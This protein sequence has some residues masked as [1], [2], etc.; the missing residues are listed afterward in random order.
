MDELGVDARDGLGSVSGGDGERER[1]SYAVSELMACDGD[2]L[3]GHRAWQIPRYA[4]VETK[5]LFNL[6]E[7]SPPFR[8]S[9]LRY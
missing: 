4:W 2:T 5:R 9:G 3:S 7:I 8:T 6:L 1:D